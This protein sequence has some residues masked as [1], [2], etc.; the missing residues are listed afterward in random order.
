MSVVLFRY[1]HLSEEI[2]RACRLVV[3]TGMHALGW[4]RNIGL[5]LVAVCNPEVFFVTFC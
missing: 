3:D 2:F 4:T 1:G 5:R